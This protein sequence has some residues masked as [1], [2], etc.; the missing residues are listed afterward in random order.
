M[1]DLVR[2]LS[3]I[4][5]NHVCLLVTMVRSRLLSH[6]KTEL[7]LGFAR[8]LT[9]ELMLAVSKNAFK[10]QVLVFVADYNV[11]QSFAT[12]ASKGHC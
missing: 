5:D 4:H 7:K 8:P 6:D 10:S 9:S 3:V 12:D 2:G 11:L 1:W